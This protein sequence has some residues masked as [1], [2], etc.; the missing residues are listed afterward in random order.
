MTEREPGSDSRAKE[1][2]DGSNIASLGRMEA[3]KRTD[4]L[5]INVRVWALKC[6]T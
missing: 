3:Y 2:S 4:V 1:D 6:K 5:G